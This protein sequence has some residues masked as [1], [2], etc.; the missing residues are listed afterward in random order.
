MLA[1]NV[2]PAKLAS[3]RRGNPQGKARGDPTEIFRGEIVVQ[4]SDCKCRRPEHSAP[5]AATRA[6]GQSSK[7][8]PPV[9]APTFYRFVINLK[10][11]KTLGFTVPLPLLGLED[12]V[13][14]EYISEVA[15]GS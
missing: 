7:P 13:I 14:E 10:T 5:D 12:G 6:S 2:G 4:T 1:K 3:R 8:D 11:T 9:Q 15:Y